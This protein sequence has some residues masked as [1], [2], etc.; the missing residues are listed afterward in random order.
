G[1]FLSHQRTGVLGMTA[2]HNIGDS[3]HPPAMF[4]CQGHHALAID[5]GH[6]LALA[7]VTDHF[8]TQF[9]GYPK[10]HAN[11]GTAPVEP[12]HETWARWRSPMHMGIDAERPAVAEDARPFRLDMR[13]SWPP[14]ERTVAK[15][16]KI[17]HFVL[18]SC[19][20]EG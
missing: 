5:I 15:D 16:P 20:Q 10:G 11:A 8:V 9:A 14:H 18:T 4:K 6:Q 13:K 19:R 17:V 7:K 3:L 2:V 12:K 1:R